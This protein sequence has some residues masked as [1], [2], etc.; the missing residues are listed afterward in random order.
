MYPL[1][2]LPIPAWNFSEAMNMTSGHSA[3]PCCQLRFLLTI[4]E[5][6]YFSE[7]GKGVLG[8]DDSWTDFSSEQAAAKRG[9]EGAR[10]ATKY[11]T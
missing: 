2:H 7:C 1:S 8:V 3:G 10:L 5:C 6:F 11:L 9:A 4:S